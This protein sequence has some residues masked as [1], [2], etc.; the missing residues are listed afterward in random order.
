MGSSILLFVCTI[1]ITKML[2]LRTLVIA[3]TIT[4]TLQT[5]IFLLM[6]VINNLYR[7][8][9][10][11]AYGSFCLAI[12]FI[13]IYLRGFGSLDTV[14]IL[15][16][17][18]LSVTAVLLFFFGTKRLLNLPLKRFWSLFFLGIFTILIMYYSFIFD[19]LNQRTILL[20]VTM[21][22]LLIRISGLLMVNHRK[23]YRSSAWMLS[24]FFMIVGVFFAFRA[25]HTVVHPIE[26]NNFFE[27]SSIQALTLLFSL[28]FGII[29]TQGVIL[30]VNQKLQ[31]ELTEKTEKLESTN[32]EKD[33]FFSVL[34]HDLRGPLTTIMGMVDLMADKNS[35]LGEKLMQE[36]A[37]AM[38]GSVHSTNILLDNLLDWANLQRGLKAIHQ[39]NTTY[40]ELIAPEMPTLLVQAENKNITII[41][42]IPEST[43][44]KADPI[45][46]QS[47]FRNLITNAIK[48]TPT[49]GTIRLISNISDD[50]RLVFSIVDS[51]IGM[52]NQLLKHL[53]EFGPRSQR[54]GTN[55]E[56]SNGLGLMICKE[57]VEKHGGRIWVESVVNK[58]STFSFC[59]EPTL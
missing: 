37:S 48:F 17:N 15:V 36:M 25:V 44:L 14:L 5:I 51:G 26:G 23:S 33:I 58:G 52:D 13:S 20:S 55:G 3:L 49:N 46:V 42:D 28:C 43:P 19:Q 59:L 34:A 54:P 22:L 11:W 35:K 10:L 18:I 9:R 24:S 6:T 7:G 45:L 16:S 30:L 8:M 50:G 41:D 47:V 32:N 38:M 4:Y 12:S 31:G 27:Y 53:F 2:D 56:S 1:P 39:I 40:G 29:C 57:F 21:A